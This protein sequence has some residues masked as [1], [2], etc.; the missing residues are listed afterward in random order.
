MSWAEIEG[1]LRAKWDELQQKRA[2]ITEVSEPLR[3]ARDAYVQQ[4][5]A[6]I[7]EFDNAIKEAET[8]LYELDNER[9]H[10]ARQLGAKSLRVR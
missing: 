10:V 2:K 9:A 1:P 7:A 6:R 8:G 3:K 4:T 5:S